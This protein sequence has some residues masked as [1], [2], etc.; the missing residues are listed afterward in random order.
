GLATAGHA[1]AQPVHIVE[2]GPA[3]GV[4]GAAALAEALGEPRLITF[5][6]G[7]TTAKAGLVEHG[8]IGRTEALEV[9]AGVMAGSRLLVGAGY[10]LKLPAID[11]AEVGAGGGS[12]CRLDP[13]GAPKV[14]PDS[15]GAVPGPVCYRQGGQEPTITDCNLALGY[16][17]PAGLAGGALPLDMEAARA[18]IA[19][20]LAAPLGL[21]VEAAAAGM[22]RLA[23]ASMMRAIRA[24]T[25]ERGRDPR[26]FA[27][28][29]FGG[30]GPLFATA[31]A[32]ALGITRVIVPPLPGVFSAFGLLV[33]RMEHHL[34]QSLRARLPGADPAPLR[35]ALAALEAEAT[36]RLHHDG[37]PPARQTRQRA[38]L[39]R[40][41]GQSSE[42][43][44]PL[45]AGE[46]WP[47]ALPELFACA[48]EATYGFR[49][50]P[51]E[52]VELM[53]LA[54]TA[55]GRPEAPLLPAAIPPA[56]QPTPAWRRAWFPD[57]GWTETPVTDRAGLRA[58]GAGP[59]I[60]QEYDATTLVP[61]GWHAAL[62]GFGAIRLHRRP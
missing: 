50:D 39:A 16:L 47:E 13:A 29:A 36:R 5:D 44:V 30:N 35:A 33:A 62:D 43:P 27:L 57:Q 37:F 55:A 8:S 49:A 48:H 2:S 46:A 22:I 59:L 18:V 42:I 11:L 40:Y 20:R 25:V 60:V 54:V 7:G 4:V 58:L 61:A 45:P 9:G 38:A 34:T 19:T 51:G 41:L 26:E 12:L 56:T 31:I 17:D 32:E 14:G 1:A 3:A 53:G 23:A 15:A 10:L 28:L 24:V 52:P 21:S 6:M